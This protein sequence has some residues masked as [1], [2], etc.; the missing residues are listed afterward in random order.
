MLNS[1]ES[2]RVYPANLM[3]AKRLKKAVGDQII[4][5][6]MVILTQFSSLIRCLGQGSATVTSQVPDDA[7]SEDNLITALPL[8]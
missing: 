8:C 4:S 2:G 7:R 5:K 6:G 3:K 1:H